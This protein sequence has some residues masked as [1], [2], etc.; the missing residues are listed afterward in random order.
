[1]LCVGVNLVVE[2]RVVM[3][4]LSVVQLVLTSVL[5]RGHIIASQWLIAWLTESRLAI[6]ICL[7]LSSVAQLGLWHARVLKFV[8]FNVILFLSVS[9]W[10]LEGSS[11]LQSLS[12]LKRSCPS[13]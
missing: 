5:L 6:N 13:S 1:M 9:V 2:V 11:A 8:Y 4:V 10:H 7:D 3:M 12:H